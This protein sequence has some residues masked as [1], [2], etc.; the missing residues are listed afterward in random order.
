[1]AART[2]VHRLL[3]DGEF[4]GGQVRAVGHRSDRHQLQ[5]LA[6]EDGPRAGRGR[7][8]AHDPVHAQR[9][10]RPVHLRVLDLKFRRER[11]AVG[12]LRHR[13]ERAVLDAVHG[14]GEQ[15][16]PGEGQPG[17]QV[18]AGVGGPHLLR[19]HP[20]HR[21]GVQPFLDEEGGGAGHL[22]ARQDRVLHRGG[23]APRGE[24]REVQVDPAVRGNVQGHLGEQRSVGHH[25]AAV[26][27]DL[28]QPGEE[29][30]VARLGG[31]EH[32][33]TGLRRAL[34]DRAGDQAPA[35]AGGG[36]GP[37]D[38][39]DDLVPVRG[40]QGIQGGYGDLGGAGEDEP[41]GWRTTSHTLR[42]GAPVY[43]PHLRGACEQTRAPHWNPYAPIP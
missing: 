18:A 37:G 14:G 8:P 21:P 42:N 7:T 5:P 38:D 36:V 13:G 15:P 25:R 23:A 41:H 2:G 12:R 27:R 40:D 11:D 17:Q 28:P 31:L 4:A 10:R 16:G 39:G 3:G 30:L 1:M 35:A 33:D 22:V 32:L 20:E 24:Q 34:G 43:G 6:P 9:G 29:V 26:R 19:H